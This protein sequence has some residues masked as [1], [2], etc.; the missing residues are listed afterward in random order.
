MSNSD[1]VLLVIA[2]LM[3]LAFVG[4]GAFALVVGVRTAT[5]VRRHGG[6]AGAL[7][8]G[9]V[10]GTYAELMAAPQGIK[11]IKLRVVAVERDPPAL[12]LEIHT[13]TFASFRLRAVRITPHEAMAL[14]DS[15]EQAAD[16][17]Q[18]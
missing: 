2:G 11:R 8:D 17:V 7:M 4:L 13:Q 14:A 15:L 18:S 16:R 10:A 1:V 6:V 3:L 12:G 9:R 5:G